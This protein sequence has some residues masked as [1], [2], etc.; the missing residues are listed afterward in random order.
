MNKDEI[1]QLLER[2]GQAISAGELEKVSACWVVPAVL[3]SDEG[4]IVLANASEIEALMARASESYRSQ[5]IVST[6]PEI[7]RI[8]MLSEKIAS[9]DVRWPSLDKSG[10]EKATERSHYL[11]QLD[12]DGQPRIRV[13][14]T[15]TK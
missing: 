15:R 11:L 14:L 7:E 12:K 1:R 13:A 6:R 9:V 2:L 10:K 5:G 8:E 4:A 3:L